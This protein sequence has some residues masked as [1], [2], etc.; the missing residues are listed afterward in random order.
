MLSVILA[1]LIKNRR[2]NN[3]IVKK[4]SKQTK[5]RRVSVKR[6]TYS[7]LENISDA[8]KTIK[9]WFQKIAYWIKKYWQARLIQMFLQGVLLLVFV[10]G[11]VHFTMIIKRIE[12]HLSSR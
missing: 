8:M 9:K 5:I 12:G 1:I 7:S 2:K 11:L 6:Y 3:E 10:Y 4:V